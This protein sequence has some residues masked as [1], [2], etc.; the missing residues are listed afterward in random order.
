MPVLPID[1]PSNSASD[2]PVKVATAF[3][4]DGAHNKVGIMALAR[5]EGTWVRRL[6]DHKGRR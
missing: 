3:S 4:S 2:P 6:Q 5:H 1:R